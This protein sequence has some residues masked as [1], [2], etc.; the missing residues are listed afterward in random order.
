MIQKDSNLVI[1]EVYELIFDTENSQKTEKNR[2]FVI[3]LTGV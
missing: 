3:R 1:C 2:I